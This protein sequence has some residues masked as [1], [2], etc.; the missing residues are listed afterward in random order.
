M[1]SLDALF[2]AER[3][4]WR[5]S[6]LLVTAVLAPLCQTG[7]LAIIFWFSESRIRM[8]KPGLRLWLELNFVVWNLVVLP[9]ITALIC[10]LSW[11]Q[12]REA[13]AWNLLLIQ[14]VPRSTHYLVK[15]LGH[16]FLILLAQMLFALSLLVLGL[17]LKSKPDPLMIMGHLHLSHLVHFLGYSVLASVALVAFHTWLSMRIPGLWIALAVALAGSWGALR[18]VGGPIWAQV[19]PWGLAAQMAIIFERWRVL[20]WTQVPL[21]LLLAAVLLVLGTLDFSRHRETRS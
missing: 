8:F 11:E 18:L 19:L 2:A 21:S 4:K 10:E 16:F 12:E 7:F 13:R 5:K 1:I 14:P 9:V 6:W 3:V 15:A 17:L 20:P